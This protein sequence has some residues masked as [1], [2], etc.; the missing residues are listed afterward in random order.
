MSL[1]EWE[2]KHWGYSVT[3]QNLPNSFRN[4]LFDSLG[5]Y[6]DGDVFKSSN[7]VVF[8]VENGKIIGIGIEDYRKSYVVKYVAGFHFFNGW[9]IL[10]DKL[11][12]NDFIMEEWLL[13]GD[14]LTVYGK[15]V[16]VVEVNCISIQ[17]PKIS[18]YINTKIIEKWYPKD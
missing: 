11:P 16:E 14:L 4:E 7:N 6:K 5:E 13:Q 17:I 15:N 1:E 12:A 8:T 2:T 18:G 3:S 10:C 9:K